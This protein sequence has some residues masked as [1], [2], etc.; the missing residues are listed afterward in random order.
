MIQRSYLAEWRKHA[1]WPLATQVEQDLVL[2]RAI[3]EIFSDPLL[4]STLAF[5]GGTALHKLYLTPAARYSEDI[6]LVQMHPGP[7]GP[8]MTALRTRL[9]PWLGVPKWKQND[10]RVT[11]I[12]RFD[13]E[14]EPVTKMR[15]K[16]EINT[17]EHFAVHDWVAHPFSVEN[18]WFTGQTQVTTY[19]LEELL[20]T[21]GRD[22]FDL[23]HTLSER[24]ALDLERV[25]TCFRRY[26]LEG[27]TPISRG[28]FEANLDAKQALSSFGE[29]IQ[30]L[31]RQD[32]KQ[33]DTFS[34]VE[35]LK[36]VRQ[37]FIERL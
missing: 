30:I 16:V 26:I 23:A 10:G 33:M 5:R 31:L 9:D 37:H 22:L 17:R 36:K 19:L 11:F 14:T 24:P 27:K 3:V 29:D 12:Y 8:A 4:Q 21:K 15:L 28:E 32:T 34:V 2:S 6:D 7:I 35:A 13:S 25:T 20:G 1:P 18:A